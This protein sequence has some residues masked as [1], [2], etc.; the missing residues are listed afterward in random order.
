[1]TDTTPAPG[2]ISTG[3][4]PGS[5]DDLP[6][7]N[8]HPDAV[9]AAKDATGV[10]ADP[11]VPAGIKLDPAS[12]QEIG[13]HIADAIS[14]PVGQD[15]ESAAIAGLP[16]WARGTIYAGLGA[17]GTAGTSLLGFALANPGVLPE[18]LVVVAAVVAAPSNAIVGSSAFANL[19]KK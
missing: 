8:Q 1:M 9:A 5:S 19:G 7:S 14:S 10:S 15:V 2:V 17:V 11:G 6:T 4:L 16:K 3:P 12:A 18:W 13:Q